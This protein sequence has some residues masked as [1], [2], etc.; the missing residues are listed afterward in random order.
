[1]TERMYDWGF[2]FGG[3]IQ[4]DEQALEIY[5]PWC[6]LLVHVP[7]N[8]AFFRSHLFRDE[9]TFRFCIDKWNDAMPQHWLHIPV[10][11]IEGWDLVL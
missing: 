9:K 2:G 3:A 10:D 1:M 5:Q 4:T 7:S 8:K 6:Y 11:D